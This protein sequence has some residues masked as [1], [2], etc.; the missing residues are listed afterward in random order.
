[1]LGG[2]DMRYSKIKDLRED[3]DLRQREVAKLLKVRRS[4]Y[5]MWELGDVNFPVEKLI[6]LANILHTNIEYLLNL[7]T[8]KS[9][10]CYP[11]D[12]DLVIIGNK[13]RDYRVKIGKTQ[14][15]FAK[16]LGIRQ[17]S[18]SY[19]EDGR[20]RIPTDRLVILVKVYHIPLN[21]LFRSDSKVV[22]N[23]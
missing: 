12:I 22:N 3:N 11:N 7:C 14:K 17:S 15:D 13:L 18:Y 16:T 21:D 10:I 8:D 9:S 23:F 1:M 4:T 20:T 19:Y 2:K 6:V 5:T